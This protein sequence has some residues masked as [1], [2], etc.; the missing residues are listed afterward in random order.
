MEVSLKAVQLFS[1]V[2]KAQRG[3]RVGK[4]HLWH[5]FRLD[6]CLCCSDAH[7]EMYYDGPPVGH[8]SVCIFSVM[9]TSGGPL[10]V[11]VEWTFEAP[12]S[13]Q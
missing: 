6:C 10:G 11:C 5:H 13:V 12:M 2:F 7:V 3:A 4:R 9:A 1:L 8:R